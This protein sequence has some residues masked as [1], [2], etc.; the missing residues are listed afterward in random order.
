MRF[1][2]RVA[3]I[4]TSSLFRMGSGNSSTLPF[5]SVA[6]ARVT[7]EIA[8]AL[9]VALLA[10]NQEG[11]NT[12]SLYRAKCRKFPLLCEP[13]VAILQTYIYSSDPGPTD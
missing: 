7:R 3:L 2:H 11:T 5:N 1:A 4:L 13:Q 9:S 8:G 6:R 10:K 12:R